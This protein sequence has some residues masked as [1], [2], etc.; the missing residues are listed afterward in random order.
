LHLGPWALGPAL[1]ALYHV[2]YTLRP[3]PHTPHTTTHVER[4]HLHPTERGS[5]RVAGGRVCGVSAIL[6]HI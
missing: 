5:E 1:C 3:K 4:N 2:P 6:F